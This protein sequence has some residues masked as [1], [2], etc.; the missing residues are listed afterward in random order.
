MIQVIVKKGK[1][2]AERTPVPVCSQGSA[3]VKVRYSCI[4]A[5]TEISAVQSGE[6]SLIK[7]ALQQPEKIRHVL[8][9]IRSTGVAETFH[10]VKSTLETGSPLG[11]SL[12]GV[13]IAAGEGVRDLQVGDKVACAG[14]GKATHAEVV[15]VP[16]N[17]IVRVPS[18]LGFQ[19]ASTVA[20]GAIAVQA[21]R[22]ARLEFGEFVV[23]FGLGGIGQIV[24]QI[25]RNAG[26]RLIAIDLDSRRLKIAGGNGAVLTLNPGECDVVREVTH[27]TG[28]HGAD[29]VIFTAATTSSEP[30]QQAF[31]MTRSKGTV[32]LVGVS[33]MEIRREDLYAKEIDFLIATSY[34]PG[35]YDEAYEGKGQDYP[36][37]YVR[38]TENRNMEEYLRQLA[39]G[40]IHL[41]NVIEKVFP[42]EAAA[43]AFEELKKTDRPLLSLLEYDQTLPEN[44]EALY[45]KESK[46]SVSPALHKTKGTV[47]V[48][49]IGPGGFAAS[50][51][52]PNLERLRDK[53][54]IH[55][56]AGKTPHKVKAMAERFHAHYA[57][58]R[59]EDV[60]GDEKV[61]LIL[62]S[63]RHNTHGEYVLKALNAGKHVFVEK[64]LCVAREELSRIQAFYR[65]REDAADPGRPVLTVGFN[66]RFSRLA[67]E[68]K[69]LTAT[70]INPLFIHYRV[71]AGYLPAEHW[72]HG[73]EGGG[74]I[75]GEACHFIDFFT[76]LTGSRVQVLHTSAL[77]PKT[78][79]LSSQDNRVIV[80]NYEDGSVATL[81][82]FSTGSKAF[83]KEYVEVHFDGKTITIDDY[84]SM[85]GYG[86]TLGEVKG[87]PPGK[88]HLEELEALYDVLSGKRENWP[89]ELWDMIQTTE[90]TLAVEEEGH[91][92]A[93]S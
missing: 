7:R 72:V 66:R 81:E 24:L 22:R 84:R 58:C 61:D 2:L 90:V 68:V 62:I 23:V 75:I 39:E 19:E 73:E 93:A 37:A 27:F 80:L 74:R 76:F 45:R 18:P 86:V 48:A 43:E 17:L 32:V 88:G 56:I 38:W 67:Q 5:G 26:A 79:S 20:L 85:R 12:S 60:L 33:G 11:Y 65:S 3:L 35:R 63:T 9:M 49:I 64:P 89:I 44:L 71:N 46:V 14:S 83:P 57:T 25:A 53:F 34:G 47:N 41:R 70:R 52:L 78:G 4:S 31:Q 40:R 92:C 87:K 29:K 50:T 82:Y 8:D 10:Q 91:S 28:G 42:I 69:R 15:D 6:A 59:V 54:R 1:V 51:H 77:A 16:R 36:Y 21:A 55:A 13:V 30:L